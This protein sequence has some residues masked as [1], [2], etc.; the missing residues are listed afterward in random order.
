V[1]S[2]ITRTDRTISKLLRQYLNNVPAKHEIKELQ[3][4]KKTAILATA[5]KLRKVLM[6]KYKTLNMRNN[7]TPSINFN[8]IP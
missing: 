2:V 4:K 6:S 8:Y 7:F 5:H 3:K 1:I